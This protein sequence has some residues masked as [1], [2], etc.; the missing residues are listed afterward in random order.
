M[1]LIYLSA[2]AVALTSTALLAQEAPRAR[3]PRP[4]R[5]ARALAWPRALDQLPLEPPETP[6]P[7]ATATPPWAP[8]PPELPFYWD[9]PEPAPAAVAPL[10]P[11]WAS[12]PRPPGAAWDDLDLPQP[13]RFNRQGTPEDSV[14]RAAR[15]LLNRGEYRRAS[16]LFHSF[17]QRF[18][19]SR[20]VPAAM[21]W[22]AFSLYRVGAEPELRR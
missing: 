14:Y 5:P 4:P 10:P 19:N 8:E 22:Q 17:E 21:Y 15:E 20:F 1:R 11:E 9:W 6:L 12:T 3:A 2:I 13:A 18:P 7:P 16:D